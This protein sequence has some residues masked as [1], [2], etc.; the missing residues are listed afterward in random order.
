LLAHQVSG[1]FRLTFVNCG[2]TEM[3]LIVIGFNLSM[4]FL[5]PALF[6][7]FGHT[8]SLHA[9]SVWLLG[10]VLV[11]V[12]MINIFKTARDLARQG[13]QPVSAVSAD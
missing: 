5:G 11:S 1:D 12:F 8:M 4:Y 6:T 7:V 13:E 9:A 3:R 2:P 10:A